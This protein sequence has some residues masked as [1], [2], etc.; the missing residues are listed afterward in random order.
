MNPPLRLCLVCRSPLDSPKATLC[1]QACRS[2]ASKRHKA[3][4]PIENPYTVEEANALKRRIAYLEAEV[5]RL[6]K[7]RKQRKDWQSQARSATARF[8]TAQKRLEAKE[9]KIVRL[10]QEISATRHTARSAR[11]ETRHAYKNVD[12]IRL[13]FSKYFPYV[14]AVKYLYQIN[15]LVSQYAKTYPEL[16]KARKTQMPGLYKFLT[17]HREQF[18]AWSQ[19]NFRPSSRDLLQ[20]PQMVSPNPSSHPRTRS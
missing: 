14:Q 5:A 7:P 13:R 18:E 9:A 1:S 4:K 20:D 6:E 19:T 12:K 2:K 16:A 15:G 8:D 3:G 11:T 10:E 17:T